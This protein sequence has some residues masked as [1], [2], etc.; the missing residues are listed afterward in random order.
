MLPPAA[1]MRLTVQ[2]LDAT[3]DNVRGWRQPLDIDAFKSRKFALPVHSEDTFAQVWEKIEQRYKTNYLDEKQA[4]AFTIK[5]LQDAYDC[6]LDLGDTVS[7]IFEG[8]TDP[9]MRTIKVVPSFIDR[10]FSVPVTSNLRPGYAQKRLLEI[11][12]EHANKRRRV[13]RRQLPQIEE[14]VNTLRDQPVP[15]TESEPSQN[16]D[17]EGG[18]DGIRGGSHERRSQTG[19]SVVLVSNTQ[20]GQAEFAEEVKEESPELGLPPPRAAKHAPSLKPSLGL[21]L[22]PTVRRSI[23]PRR[24]SASRSKTPHLPPREPSPQFENDVPQI[25]DAVEEH[26]A[27]QD[28]VSPVN[29]EIPSAQSQ[30]SQEIAIQ[31][32]PQSP[33]TSTL[34]TPPLAASKR[35]NVYDVPSSPEFLQRGSTNS[36]KAKKTYGRSPRTG[37]TIQKEV[38]LL[39]SSRRLSA[40]TPTDRT[41]KRFTPQSSRKSARAFHLPA[42]DEIES[43]PQEEISR[44]H[45]VGSE[46]S[47][48]DLTSA[49][50]EDTSTSFQSSIRTPKP[51]RPGNLKKPTKPAAIVTPSSKKHE[52]PALSTDPPSS[53][54]NRSLDSSQKFGVSSTPGSNGKKPVVVAP[55]IQARLD[56]LRLRQGQRHS[57]PRVVIP[58]GHGLSQ[59]DP[60]VGP[61]I[62]GSSSNGR[63]TSERAASTTPSRSAVSVE[64]HS[65]GQRAASSTGSGQTFVHATTARANPARSPIPLPENVRHLADPQNSGAQ[66]SSES[67]MLFKKPVPRLRS[68]LSIEHT[69]AAPTPQKVLPTGSQSRGQS[70]TTVSDTPDETSTQATARTTGLRNSFGSN[71]NAEPARTDTQ[72]SAK[73]SQSRTATAY[74]QGNEPRQNPTLPTAAKRRPGRPRKIAAVEAT[75]VGSKSTKIKPAI[76]LD[77]AKTV[78]TD[79]V[80]GESVTSSA[81]VISS[82]ESLSS[83]ATNE[84]AVMHTVHSPV[85]G[86]P[87]SINGTKG[88]DLNAPGQ[89]DTPWQPETWNFGKVQSHSQD[90]LEASNASL[91]KG[92]ATSPPLP[93]ADM[94]EDHE[95]GAEDEAEN[96][97]ETGVESEMEGEGTS[98]SISAT[99]STRSSPVVTHQP[100][101][102]LS[103]S[104]TPQNSISDDESDASSVTSSQAAKSPVPQPEEDS[105]TESETSADSEGPDTGDEY[106]EK[107]SALVNALPEPATSSDTKN[108]TS[109][110][111]HAR[112]ALDP[113]PSILGTSQ[114]GLSQLPRKTPVPL[115]ANAHPRSSQSVSERAAERQPM[116]RIPSF[117]PLRE[118]LA[119]VKSTPITVHKKTFDARN[120]NLAK[121][122]AKSKA[123]GRI[124]LPTDGSG[125]D[126][127]DDESSES[128]ESSDSD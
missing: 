72:R 63:R 15:T 59:S 70:D 57:S 16:S 40:H 62:E 82:T 65:S 52:V 123:A 121:L 81:I 91:Q 120:L 9:A 90:R 97:A 51:F 13:E 25:G 77:G 85:R 99:F 110:P 89:S 78:G 56:A 88:N 26:N 68:S 35:P 22:V 94:T 67:T 92:R 47:E 31:R 1:R 2:V 8:E 61:A 55:A 64:P 111:L 95:F 86:L 33:P 109:S 80:P 42:N 102:F 108:I 96:E 101:K 106:E 117:K 20:T 73:S 105:G 107:R 115:P 100:A 32:S 18:P 19:G 128:S 10:D 24:P 44:S 71:Q 122:A 103:H 79:V 74:V 37:K 125:S 119:A 43:T 116:L 50:L 12:Q 58:Q 114:R 30:N 36:A 46:Q 6:D 27:V 124:A 118:Q 14:V 83:D 66:E 69:I 7:S 87:D 84:T 34:H 49:F 127:D 29:V 23:S 53:V 54:R 76:E 112:V 113:T 75:N 93:A 48:P 126:D 38:D 28:I 17:G 98:R 4:A 21:P 60:E 11:N 5:K 41:G 39:N 104:P 3:R 45:R